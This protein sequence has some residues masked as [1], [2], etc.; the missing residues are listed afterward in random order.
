M[1]DQVY[2]HSHIYP[3][4][5]LALD[6]GEDGDVESLRILPMAAKVLKW[7]HRFNN[8]A[9][10]AIVECKIASVVYDLSCNIPRTLLGTAMPTRDRATVRRA[11]AHG[12]KSFRLLNE[13]EPGSAT[14]GICKRNLCRAWAQAESLEFCNLYDYR[15]AC[16]DFF[17]AVEARIGAAPPTENPRGFLAE[18]GERSKEACISLRTDPTAATNGHSA[19]FSN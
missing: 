1:R 10:T 16:P 5:A 17:R 7:C 2:E 3:P 8:R 9:M 11:I 15:E 13:L 12:V 19:E 18:M 4:V 14:M 6:V